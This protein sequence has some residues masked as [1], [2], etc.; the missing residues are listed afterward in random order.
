MDGVFL[1]L[2]GQ[3]LENPV[4]PSSFTWINPDCAAAI[5][6]TGYRKGRVQYMEMYKTTREQNW[7]CVS[8]FGDATNSRCEIVAAA[9]RANSCS[10]VPCRCLKTKPNQTS[11]GDNVSSVDSVQ[12]G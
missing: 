10:S 12:Q 6:G 3:L 4:H 11:A 7:F 8:C 2:A 1:G 5:E 9:G